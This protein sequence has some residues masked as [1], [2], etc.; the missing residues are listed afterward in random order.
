MGIR[1]AFISMHTD[2]LGETGARKRLI[3]SVTMT[4]HLVS[5]VAHHLITPCVLSIERRR[6]G[7]NACPETDIPHSDLAQAPRTGHA[8]A[9]EKAQSSFEGDV[10][11]CFSLVSPSNSVF[12]IVA[13]SEMTF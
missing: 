5:P 12:Q 9:L 13:G 2:E 11:R 8:P 1:R 7:V 4:H 6:R 3:S 10:A